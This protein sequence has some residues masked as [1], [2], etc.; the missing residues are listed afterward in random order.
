[1]DIKFTRAVAASL[2]VFRHCYV[3]MGY[4]CRC[5]HGISY[6][7]GAG[8]ELKAC[9]PTCSLAVHFRWWRHIVGVNR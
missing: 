6:P 4:G 1:M 2:S 3:S 5:L 8:G 7:V 9:T